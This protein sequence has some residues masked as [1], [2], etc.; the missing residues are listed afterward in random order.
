MCNGDGILFLNRR[1]NPVVDIEIAMAVVNPLLVNAI[2]CGRSVDFIW[3]A[4]SAEAVRSIHPN[5]HLA[6]LNRILFGAIRCNSLRRPIIRI[7]RIGCRCVCRLIA[8]NQN[9]GDQYGN[10]SLG[11]S[12][13][14]NYSISRS[15]L[16]RLKCR[17]AAKVYRT[18]GVLAVLHDVFA[19]C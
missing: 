6:V 14:S 9:E 7:T 1:Q 11:L 4:P 10:K 15:G 16:S 18:C 12:H 13:V 2:R 17:R 19:A 3:F 5:R 8:R